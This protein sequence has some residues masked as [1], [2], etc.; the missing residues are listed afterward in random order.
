MVSLG[1]ADPSA[2]RSEYILSSLDMLLAPWVPISFE[3]FVVS[4]GEFLVSFC[5]PLPMPCLGAPSICELS[6]SAYISSIHRL[7]LL[8]ANDA[9]PRHQ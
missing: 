8:S 9:G 2:S 1:H 6:T 4:V 7:H 5:P 3:V